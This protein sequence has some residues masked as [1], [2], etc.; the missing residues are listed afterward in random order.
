MGPMEFVLGTEANQN[1]DN[2]TIKLNQR[3]YT[4]DML[5][6]S[7]MWE[8]KPKLTPMQPNSL[9]TKRQCSTTD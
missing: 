8:I 7:D 4:E 6:K 1:L 5:K 2:K 3:R 9:L